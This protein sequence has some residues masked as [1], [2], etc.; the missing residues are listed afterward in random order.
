MEINLV[1]GTK[2]FIISD[3]HGH[4]N[5]MITALNNAGFNHNSNHI[6]IVL[7]DM[8]DRGN[9]SKE[10]LEYLHELSL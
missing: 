6:L 1:K 8:F 10:V 3:I 4:Y 9:Q 7:G 2:Y 5:E